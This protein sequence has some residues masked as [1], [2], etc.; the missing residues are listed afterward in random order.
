MK[1]Y[2]LEIIAH[3]KKGYYESNTLFGL[4]FT[5][6]KHKLSHFISNGKWQ[7]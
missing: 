4:I 2:R 7:D 5:R 3:G 6:F 1:K